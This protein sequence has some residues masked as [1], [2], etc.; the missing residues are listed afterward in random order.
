[1]V[2]IL[3]FGDRGSTSKR[4]S[5]SDVIDANEKKNGGGGR[6]FRDEREREKKSRALT[7]KQLYISN[8]NRV[9]TLKTQ[10]PFQLILVD[11]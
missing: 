11:C 1:M 2:R 5:I 6:R 3:S 7:G 4:L 10:R 9:K 8:R